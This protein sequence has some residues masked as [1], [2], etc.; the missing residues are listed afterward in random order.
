MGKTMTDSLT[1]KALRQAVMRRN[2]APGLIV[3]TDQGSQY[4]S[5]EFRHAVKQI[6]GIP[7]MSRKGNCWDN[8]CA[9]SFFHTL[10]SELIQFTRYK[11]R[12][13]ARLSIFEYIEFFYNRFRLHST[14]GYKSPVEFEK[15]YE[16]A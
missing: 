13:E 6:G 1:I 2:P 5:S 11:R 8:A 15:Y 4:T 9:E 10:K 7:S 16:A 12:S 3:H 14:L